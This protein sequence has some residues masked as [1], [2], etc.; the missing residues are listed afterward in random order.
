CHKGADQSM[1]NIIIY[2][3]DD[4]QTSV[5]LYANDGTVWLTQA[6]IAE[7]FDRSIATISRHIANIFAEKE[8]E[9]KA[10][11]KKCKLLFRINR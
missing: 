8:L 7:L 3:P 1:D 4:G 9:E 2:N 6:Q 5:K 11:Y 10:I